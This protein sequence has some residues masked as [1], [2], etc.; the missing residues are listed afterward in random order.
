MNLK[1]HLCRSHALS[2]IHYCYVT[3]HDSEGIR[4]CTVLKSGN[5]HPLFSCFR[6]D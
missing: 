6:V 4:N 3:L 5:S 2:L 1:E